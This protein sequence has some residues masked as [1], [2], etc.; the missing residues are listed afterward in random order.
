[1]MRLSP[2]QIYIEL[3]I[4]TASMCT[5]L[6]SLCSLSAEYFDSCKGMLRSVSEGQF[7]GCERYSTSL[8][9]T[10]QSLVE[11]ETGTISSSES[12]MMRSKEA[13]KAGKE[14][15]GSMEEIE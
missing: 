5:Y 1:M 13:V 6:E 4:D 11:V 3:I 15:I 7:L 8:F 10:F 2:N 9:N 12:E 14:L